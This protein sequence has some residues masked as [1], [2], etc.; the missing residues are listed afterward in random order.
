MPF[1]LD[2][3]ISHFASA[4]KTLQMPVVVCRDEPDF[5]EVYANPGAR[6]LLYPTGTTEA[7]KRGEDG[8][9]A[10][11]RYLRFRSEEAR[12]HA[13]TQLKATG[14]VDRL[15]VELEDELGAVMRVTL[16]ANLQEVA[17]ES[18]LV[19]YIMEVY[20]QEGLSVVDVN[21][22]LSVAFHIAYQNAG[23]D[24]TIQRILGYTGSFLSVDR[25][26]IFEET[27]PTLTSNTYEWCAPGIPPEKENLQSLAKE[28]Y[29]YD[30]IVQ[31]GMYITDDVCD[32]PEGDRDILEAQ[33]IKSLA[34]LPLL[35]GDH[36]LGY[37][38]L[39]DC[40]QCRQWSSMEVAMLKSISSIILTLL[41]RRN[42]D[43]R[44]ARSLNI[45]QR[46]T[47]S[48]DNAVYVNDPETY[49]II[50]VNK[51]L[52]DS[53]GVQIR[54]VLGKP[55]WSVL[56][57]GMEGPCPFCPM[58]K[59]A[60]E[61]QSYA[62]EMQNTRNKRW[63]M[64]RDSFIRWIDNRKVHIES[65]T[66]I[67]SRKAY[68]EKLVQYASFD[69]MTGTYNREWGYNLMEEMRREPG[70]REHPVS[71]VFIDLDG[72]K[73]VND[74]YGHAAGDE[75]ITRT[76][77]LLRGSV[78]R[79]DRICR[80]GGDEFILALRCDV[81]SAEQIMDKVEGR[82][83]AYNKDSGAPFRL[84]FSYGITA[85]LPP[86]QEASLDALISAAD[87]KMYENKMGKR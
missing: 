13:F 32:L 74:T 40:K 72:L 46:I 51:T 47:D 79:D 69:T 45:L 60:D 68:E 5:P 64:I 80:W 15:K 16:S 86:E 24:E 26:Y 44:V 53:L 3:A 67:T 49:E 4:Y 42:S 14:H 29:N 21:N 25:V 36:A 61:Q 59:L 12:Q 54:D 55:C 30:A 43:N 9:Q 56:Q 58:P 81:E 35:D 18:Y 6:L 84:S 34:I 31:G 71:I 38:G 20:E 1:Q 28:D 39:D 65:S 27:S 7:L 33:G 62:W 50:F 37:I 70:F 57:E 73:H 19:F 66:D 2:Q 82:I 48:S 52:A 41:T 63:Y 75:M 78:R 76:I 83:A 8:V 23:V 77:E 85:L 22:F 17:G 10:P 87:R 11:G